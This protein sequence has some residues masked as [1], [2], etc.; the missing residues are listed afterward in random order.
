MNHHDPRNYKLGGGARGPVG[1]HH[2]GPWG[3]GQAPWGRQ[4]VRL[5][6]QLTLDT[7]MSTGIDSHAFGK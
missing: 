2:G 6:P 5:T 4:S 7:H 3:P 1:S